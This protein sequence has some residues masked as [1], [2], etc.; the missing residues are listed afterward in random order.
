MKKDWNKLLARTIVLSL[1]CITLIGLCY[2]VNHEIR[3]GS[4][5]YERGWGA[6]HNVVSYTVFAIDQLAVLIFSAALL[7]WMALSQRRFTAIARIRRLPEALFAG[8]ILG[9]LYYHFRLYVTLSNYFPYFAFDWV[10]GLRYV[11][12]ILFCGWLAAMT[13]QSNQLLTEYL[14]LHRYCRIE[15]L[16]FA[17]AI[18]LGV[19]LA[20]YGWP[21]A[22]LHRESP[23]WYYGWHGLLFL[24]RMAVVWLLGVGIFRYAEINIRLQELEASRIVYLS[25]WRK[26][27]S[28]WEKSSI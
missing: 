12:L 24:W 14:T 10:V 28:F 7:V 3:L 23:L 18:L 2:F 27:R 11:V 16:A 6:I 19:G 1:V 9:V 5:F 21:I 25:F 15:R 26:C 13:R 20:D 17:A 22:G 4:Y 8:V